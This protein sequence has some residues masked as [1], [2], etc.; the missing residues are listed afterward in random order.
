MSDT[1]KSQLEHANPEPTSPNTESG[2]AADKHKPGQS[3]KDSEE[4][5][6]PHNRLGI[7]FTGLMACT[8]LAA[9]DQVCSDAILPHRNETLNRTVTRQTIVATA[10]PTIVQELGGGKEYSWVGRF[11]SS[12]LHRAR[13]VDHK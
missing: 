12:F 3:W 13:P 2:D 11:V 6:L 8:F 9:L 4:H 1:E 5:V 7:V 10:L